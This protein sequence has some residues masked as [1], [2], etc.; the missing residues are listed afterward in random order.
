MLLDWK[1]PLTLDAPRRR[2]VRQLNADRVKL[3]QCKARRAKGPKNHSTNKERSQAD[4]LKAA[5]IAAHLN[6]RA[7]AV[8]AHKAA[9]RE[10]WLGIR[11]DHPT[12]S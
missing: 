7:A 9:V 11:A 1:N 6:A 3:L 4:R 12:L 2:A 10:Y 5:E 8:A